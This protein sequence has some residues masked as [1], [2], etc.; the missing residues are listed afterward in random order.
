VQAAAGGQVL[1]QL[2]ARA[3][4]RVLPAMTAF[5]QAM[6]DHVAVLADR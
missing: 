2:Q 6:V 5:E 4:T 1:G 3:L